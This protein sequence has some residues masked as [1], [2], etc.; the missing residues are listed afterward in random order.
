[1]ND[2]ELVLEL[3]KRLNLKPCTLRG[4]E[5]PYLGEYIERPRG[6]SIRSNGA[7]LGFFTEFVL[8]GDKLVGNSIWDT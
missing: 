7:F 6:I 4:Q 2:R 5:I 3:C 1:M 8:D